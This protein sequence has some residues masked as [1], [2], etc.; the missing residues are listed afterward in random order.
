M[1]IRKRKT[2]SPTSPEYFTEFIQARETTQLVLTDVWKDTTVT[3]VFILA[4]VVRGIM[5]WVNESRKIEP[6]PEVGGFI[7]GNF[8]PLEEGI[9]FMV[10]LEQFIPSQQVDSSS[11]SRL[12]FGNQALQQLDNLRQM[13]S[14][15]QALIAWFHTHPGHTPYLS[16]TD[17][18]THEGFFPHKYQLAIVLD[19]Q[20]PHFD[21]G[22]FSRKSD[23]S[24]NNKSRD[25]QWFAWK[26]LVQ[27]L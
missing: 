13:D 8:L 22:F 23:G 16:T 10:S 25:S 7:L 20:T 19:S 4:G 5:D 14:S 26:K 1:K 21:T 27:S 17:I 24:I 2:A 3:Q 9:H 11:P 15:Q 6:V 18:S 12:E